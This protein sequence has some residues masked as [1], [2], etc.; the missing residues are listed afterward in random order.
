MKDLDKKILAFTWPR[1]AWKTY[2]L[3]LI[4]KHFNNKIISIPQISCRE[5]RIDDNEKYIKIV[6]PEIFKSKTSEMLVHNGKYWILQKDIDMAYDK[7]VIP[8]CILWWKEIIK[9]KKQEVNLIT[10]NIT[11]PL[12]DLSYKLNQDI[13]NL[14]IQRMNSRWI[15]KQEAICEIEKI[16]LYMK[17]FFNN[18][19]FQKYL[20]YNLISKENWKEL[21]KILIEIIR[22]EFNI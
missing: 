1:W 10:L 19:K 2:N 21:E 22:K 5:K 12:G 9:L 11:Y 18:P 13:E 17:L 3:D 4:L 7:W 15:N 16:I 8:T 6:T 20:D 14:V